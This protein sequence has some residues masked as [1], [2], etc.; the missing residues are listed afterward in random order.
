MREREREG[1][2]GGRGRAEREADQQCERH[3]RPI[4]GSSAAKRPSI[5]SGP[6]GVAELVDAA[7]L[8]PAEP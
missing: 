2:G 5:L 4:P 3:A 6:A 1:D 8:G 7:G